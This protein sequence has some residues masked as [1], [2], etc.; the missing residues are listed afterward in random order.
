MSGHRW[1]ARAAAGAAAVALTVTGGA[2]A[3]ADDDIASLGAEEIAD[4]SRD[5]LLGVSSLHLSARGSLDGSGDPMSVDL[6]LDREGNCAGGVDMGEDGSVEIVKRAGDVWLKPDKA[7]WE[8]HVPVGGSTFDAILDGRYMKAK[9]DDPRLLTV[10]EVCDLD[11]FRELI[12][13]NADA[14]D[15]GTLTKGRE[16]EVNGEPVIPVTRAQGDER[17]TVYVA[18]DGEPYPVRIAVRGPGEEGTVNFSGFDRPVPARTP[19]A[20]ETVDVTA[21]LGR[22]VKPV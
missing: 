7:F 8:T 3:Q 1:A 18:T 20:D 11:T 17:L 9:A 19:S 4:R 10:T 2:V 5:A 21:L 12:K 15:R 16:T 22:S 6:T 13:D 14:A